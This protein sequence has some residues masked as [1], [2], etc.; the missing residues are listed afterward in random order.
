MDSSILYD[1]II[2][3]H[4]GGLCFELNGL[5]E[6]FFAIIG[7]WG[8]DLS[9]RFF[10]DAG[11]DI[12]MQRHRLLKVEAVDGTYI[13]DIELDNVLLNIHYVYEKD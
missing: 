11:D 3:K 9:S 8:K 1:K 5:S 6:I 13:W 10:R 2:T 7:I 4:R 12:P